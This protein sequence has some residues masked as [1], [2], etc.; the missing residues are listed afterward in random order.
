MKIALAVAAAASRS[1]TPQWIVIVGQR[2]CWDFPLAGWAH[3]RSAEL[4]SLRRFLSSAEEEM[5]AEEA[6]PEDL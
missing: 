2:S 4:V 1:R 3:D 6:L 5:L